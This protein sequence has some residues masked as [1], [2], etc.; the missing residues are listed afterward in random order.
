MSLEL[1]LSNSLAKD[2]VA[3]AHLPVIDLC[4]V[5][6]KLLLKSLTCGLCFC[7][8]LPFRDDFLLQRPQAFIDVAYGSHELLSPVTL[9]LQISLELLDKQPEIHRVNG[10]AFLLCCSMGHNNV[11]HSPKWRLRKGDACGRARDVPRIGWVIRQHCRLYELVSKGANPI[12]SSTRPLTNL[13][14]SSVHSSIQCAKEVAIK[15]PTLEL[16]APITH[17][18]PCVAQSSA[19]FLRCFTEEHMQGWSLHLLCAR[20]CLQ[21]TCTKS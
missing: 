20:H 9:L 19:H 5:A 8:K 11:R 1:C 10:S 16:I 4:I 14:N 6:V 17:A 21:I 13:V 3:L 7:C 2:Q 12:N 18:C 15:V